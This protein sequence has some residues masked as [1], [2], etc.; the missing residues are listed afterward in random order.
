MTAELKK[1]K[2]HQRGALINLEWRNDGLEKK[3]HKIDNVKVAL[4]VG[5]KKEAGSVV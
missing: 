3:D 1:G 2:Q 4:G 5:S